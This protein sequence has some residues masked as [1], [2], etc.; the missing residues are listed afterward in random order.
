MIPIG[1]S[2]LRY[3]LAHT[4]RGAHH[5]RNALIGRI[6]AGALGSIPHG[7]NP[8]ATTRHTS[9]ARRSLL[10]YHLSVHLDVLLYCLLHLLLLLRHKLGVLLILHDLL[11][12]LHVYGVVLV[13]RGLRRCAHE[14]ELMLQLG[15]LDRLGPGLGPY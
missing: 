12:D 10:L 13:R 6:P 14:N 2:V 7:Q 1:Y 15:G 8:S 11:V 9:T 5:I 4:A 3:A